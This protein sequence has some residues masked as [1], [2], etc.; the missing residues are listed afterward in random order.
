VRFITVRARP[1]PPMTIAPGEEV[2]EAPKPETLPE[3]PK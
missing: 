1:A 2:F 3:K